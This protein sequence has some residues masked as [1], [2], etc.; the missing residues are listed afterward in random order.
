VPLSTQSVA[1]AID[2]VQITGQGNDLTLDLNSLYQTRA[3]GAYP[4]ALA[5]YEIVCSNYTDDQVASAVRA[6]LQTALSPN[7]QQALPD[8]GPHRLGE[9]GRVVDGQ[10]YPHGAG[11]RQRGDAAEHGQPATGVDGAA[12]AV[13]EAA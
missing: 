2:S 8:A 10:P 4:I 12:E 6:F 1:S 11:Q 5:T 3:P 9:Q 7:A 13:L